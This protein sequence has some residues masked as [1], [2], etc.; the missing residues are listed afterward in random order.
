MG[1]QQGDAVQ[2]DKTREKDITP[3]PSKVKCHKVETLVSSALIEICSLDLGSN[4]AKFFPASEFRKTNLPFLIN[5]KEVELLVLNY[6]TYKETI[7]P[8]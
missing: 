1:V 6:A 3:M 5:L 2:E 4:V 8:G 7:D